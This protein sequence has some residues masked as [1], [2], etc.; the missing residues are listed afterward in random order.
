[1]ELGLDGGP[2]IFYISRSKVKGQ[3]QISMKICLFWADFGHRGYVWGF[4]G[5]GRV[6]WGTIGS[7][8]TKSGNLPKVVE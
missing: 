1:M 3:G 7:M 4:S 8:P 2:L 5:P 6:R